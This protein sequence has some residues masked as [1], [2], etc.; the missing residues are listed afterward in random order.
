M[1][2]P[3]GKR[4]EIRREYLTVGPYQIRLSRFPKTGPPGHLRCFQQAWYDEFPWLGYLL[5]QDAAYCLYCYLFAK[6]TDVLGKSFP[7]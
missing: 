1:A 7:N 4:D 5:K 2:Y 6:K 3:P